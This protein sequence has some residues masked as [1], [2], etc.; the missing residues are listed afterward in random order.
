[1]ERNEIT[2]SRHYTP[3]KAAKAFAIYGPAGDPDDIAGSRS[4]RTEVQYGSAWRIYTR[5]RDA[6][7]LTP[8]PADPSSWSA[9]SGTCG[10]ATSRPPNT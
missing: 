1:M 9:T 2:Y 5:W 8:M 4:V 10:P 6:E 7:G 3:E